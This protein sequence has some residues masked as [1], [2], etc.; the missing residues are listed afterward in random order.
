M[1]WGHAPGW[2]CHGG[3]HLLASTTPVICVIWALAR[4]KAFAYNTYYKII[5]FTMHKPYRFY[6]FVNYYLSP[7]QQGLQTAHAVG[8]MAVADGKDAGF[9]QWAK[10]DKTIIICK[11]GNSGALDAWFSQLQAMLENPRLKKV[12]AVKFQEDE[13]SL[14]GATTVVGLLVPSDLWSLQWDQVLEK[15]WVYE[16]LSPEAVARGEKPTALVCDYV[17]SDPEYQFVAAYKAFAL[18]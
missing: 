17:P 15:M 16:P 3:A 10:D 7:L 14:G 12:K 18:A 8:D 4:R 1:V 6:S 9:H 2:L 5:L 13:A 11:G